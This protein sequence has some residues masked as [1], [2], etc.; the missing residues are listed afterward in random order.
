MMTCKSEVPQQRK[1]PPVISVIL[2]N[3][4]TDYVGIMRQE[5]AIALGGPTF[6]THS[7]WSS[8]AYLAHIEQKTKRLLSGK[9]PLFPKGI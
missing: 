9:L 6:C 3:L 4:K 5:V 1:I 7:P 8:P 2:V